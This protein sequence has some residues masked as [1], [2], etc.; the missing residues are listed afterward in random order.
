MQE[1]EVATAVV[2]VVLSVAEVAVATPVAVVAPGLDTTK[3]TGV[4]VVA[5]EVLTTPALIR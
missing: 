2:A 3:P 1:C 5:E 4:T